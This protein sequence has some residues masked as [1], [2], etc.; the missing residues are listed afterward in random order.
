MTRQTFCVGGRTGF[1]LLRVGGP[2]FTELS[3]EVVL[4]EEVSVEV[5]IEEWS[6]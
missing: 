3:I 4:V 2:T 5:S 6:G 1:V